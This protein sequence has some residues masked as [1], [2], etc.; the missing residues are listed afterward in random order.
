MRRIRVCYIYEEYIDIDDREWEYIAERGEKTCYT[1]EYSVPDDMTAY[2]IYNELGEPREIAWWA[3]NPPV[4]AL[5]EWR[6][7]AQNRGKKCS[8]CGF[9]IRNKNA[10]PKTNSYYRYCPNC[11]EKM[12]RHLDNYIELNEKEWND[13]ESVDSLEGRDF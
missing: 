9:R 5:I 12:G 7:I 6:N 1:Q 11:G 3:T 13:Y 4:D 10:I 2:Q 8:I